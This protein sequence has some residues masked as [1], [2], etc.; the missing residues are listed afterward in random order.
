MLSR[1]WATAASSAGCGGLLCANAAGLDVSSA[2]AV[3]ATTTRR[4]GEAATR[5][6]IIVAALVATLVFWIGYDGGTYGLEARLTL[7]VGVIWTGALTVVSGIW[8]ARRLPRPALA[9]GAL[10]AG[11]ALFA[12]ASTAWATS[13]ES[14]F[15]EFDRDVLYVGVFVL[16]AGLATV[17]DR[18]RIADG[19]AV[20]IVALAVCALASRF[21]PHVVSAGEVQTLLPT[22]H[23]RLSYPIEYWNGLAIL[24]ALACPLL[25]RAAVAEATLAAGLALAPIPALGAAI[26]LTSSRGGAVAAVVGVAAFVAFSGRRTLALVAIGVAALGTAAAVEVVRAR[27]GLVDPPLGTNPPGAD[28]RDAAVLVMLACLA[29]GLALAYIRRYARDLSVS[30]RTGVALASVA[31]AAI[32]AGVAL[33]HPVRRF[34]DFRK[35]P[36]PAPAGQADFVQSHLLSSSGSGRWQFWAAAVSEFRSRPLGGRGAGSYEAWWAAHGSLSAFVRNAHSLYLETLG[37]LGLVG[38]LLLA[39]AFLTALGAGA[40]LVL[41]SRGS[42][43]TTGAAALASFVAFAVAAGYDWV[44]QIAA[45]AVVGVACLS[46]AVV[47]SGSAGGT[48][49]RPRGRVRLAAAAAGIVL[50]AAQVL[51]LLSQL[52]IGDSQAAVRRG[53]TTAA[54]GDALAARDLEPWASSPYLQLALVAEQAGDLAAAHTWISD[55]LARD[56]GDW[57]LWLVAGRIEAKQG[58]VRLAG[59]SLRRA[60]KLNPRSPLF[61]S[62]R[63]R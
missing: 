26:Y 43:R 9:T 22:A 20:G 5:A 4:F 8:P 44:W 54:V 42:E 45:V 18:A 55:A 6:G 12:L 29:T 56:D 60:V 2:V 28:G 52:S 34:D 46:L 62:A 58:L 14:A 61:A 21:F 17:V 7:A 59:Q 50:L 47:G 57:R 40:R 16:V 24:L 53:D 15:S 38:F 13:A 36:L 51:P 39:G 11:F 33:A 35:P 25:L 30:R 31:V 37:E 10:L 23:A 48:R 41:T 32:V 1:Y 3:E 63:G 49:T 27:P 19:I